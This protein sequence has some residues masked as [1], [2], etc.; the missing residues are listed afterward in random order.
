MGPLDDLLK[1]LS[2]NDFLVALVLTAIF[3][4]VSYKFLSS[5]SHI[6]LSLLVAKSKFLLAYNYYDYIIC[7]LG[8]EVNS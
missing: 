2:M 6:D 5:D 3:L 1:S 4:D 8:F 7:C